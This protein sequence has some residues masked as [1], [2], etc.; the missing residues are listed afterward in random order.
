[1]FKWDF[2]FVFIVSCPFTAY[3][4]ESDSVTFIPPH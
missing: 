2:Q 4:G 3:R 1:M